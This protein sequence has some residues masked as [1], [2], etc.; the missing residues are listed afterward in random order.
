MSRMRVAVAEDEELSAKRLVRLLEEAGCEVAAT[1]REGR[2][3]AEWL[4]QPRPI[5][6][7]FLD[8]HMPNLDGLAILKSLGGRIPAVLTTA[9]PEHAVEAFDSEATDYLLKPITASRLERALKRV[10]SRRAPAEAAATA[11]LPP[12]GPQ[13]YP[14][15]AGEGVVLVDLART[16]HFEVENEVVFAHAGQRMRTAWT[17]LGEVEAAFPAAGLLRI[18]RHLLIRPEA[19]VGL[20]PAP[21]GRAFVRLTGGV[22]VEASRGGAPRLR[23]RLGL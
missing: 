9:F 12:A 14:V 19:V 2:G 8:I 11:P 21:G 20:R 1:F 18:H 6:A 23:E 13:R 7:L 17:S 15:Q 3:L 10:E 16:T 5:D 22:E 4:A